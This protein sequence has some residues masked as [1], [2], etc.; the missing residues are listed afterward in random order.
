MKVKKKQSYITLL[1]WMVEKYH[2][3]GNEL[4]AYALIYGFSQDGESQYKGSYAYLCKWLGVDRV[5]AIR[6][7]K[8]LESKGLLTKRQTLADGKTL[9]QWVAECPEAFAERPAGP[10][11]TPEKAVEPHPPDPLQNATSGKTPPVAKCNSDPLQN[12]TS[13]SCKM[14]PRYTR[15][16]TIG[17]SIYLSARSAETDGRTEPHTEQE[18]VEARFRQRLGLDALAERYGSPRLEEL[19]ANVVEM[20]CC[21][22]QYQ[23]IGQTPY[24]TPNV[25]KML[26][27]L[28]GQ[29]V[30]YILDNLANSTRPI[31]NVQGYLRACILRATST[32]EFANAAKDNA[33]RAEETAQEQPRDFLRDAA[34][35]NSLRRMK[36]AGGSA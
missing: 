11:P 29:H 4:I 9:N 25:R 7:L 14:Q 33:R 1:D 5:T 13:P 10:E 24:Y 34:L 27:K 36:K 15:G 31:H 8:R 21:P 12:A 16:N 6:L 3:K 22:N 2:L 28:T 30:A 18:S 17:K 35:K 20:Y 32:M 23:S 26:D 19:L